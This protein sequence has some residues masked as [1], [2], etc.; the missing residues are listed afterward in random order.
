MKF[1]KAVVLAIMFILSSLAMATETIWHGCNVEPDYMILEFRTKDPDIKEVILVPT[2]IAE[3]NIQINGAYFNKN[4]AYKID[5]NQI[6]Q[7]TLKK[8]NVNCGNTSR[9]NFENTENEKILGL[10]KK[11]KFYSEN[12]GWHTI[13]AEMYENEEK[14]TKNTIVWLSRKIVTIDVSSIIR[15]DETTDD[16]WHERASNPE[17]LIKDLAII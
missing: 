13:T 10:F 16:S 15:E 1:L 9:L 7:V 17:L 2:D 14:Q 3:Q 12:K 6:L 11:G 8:I 5:T 4:K